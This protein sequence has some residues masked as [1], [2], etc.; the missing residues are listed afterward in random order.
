M[1]RFEITSSICPS[2]IDVIDFVS[3]RGP[4]CRSALTTLDT[5]R[6]H[7]GAITIDCQSPI[8]DLFFLAL[9]TESQLVSAGLTHTAALWRCQSGLK[10]SLSPPC[11]Q[12]SARR[13]HL[14][15]AQCSARQ[16]CQAQLT[17]AGNAHRHGYGGS[18]LPRR[19]RP[20]CAARE[21]FV[22][23]SINIWDVLFSPSNEFISLLGFENQTWKKSSS[24]YHCD[25]KLFWNSFFSCPCTKRCIWS[26]VWHLMG[27][28]DV[29]KYFLTFFFFQ[30]DVTHRH[31]GD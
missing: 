9:H 24:F 4:R 30:R 22:V 3:P 20:A 19:H 16:P 25:K 6:M 15:S 14:S 28:K 12:L 27:N 10:Q 13:R 8:T 11:T 18:T 17:L 7:L 2:L 5:V 26:S 23:T 29:R 1:L 31:C 21:A